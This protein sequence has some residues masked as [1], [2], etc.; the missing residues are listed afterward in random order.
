MGLPVLIEG[1]SGSGK[2][3]SLK[4][5]K[6]GEIS[7]FNVAGKPL[8]FKNNGIAVRSVERLMRT[9]GIANRY[10][11]ITKAIKDS[12]TKAFAIDDSQYLLAFD[13]F[14][15]AKEFGYGK[16]TD[17]AVSFYNLIKFV[18]NDLPSDVI[19]YFLHHVELTDGGKYK[20]KTIGK[21]LDNQLTVEGLF[22]IVLFCTADENHHYF[23]TQ[24]RGISTA[25][26]PE[27]MFDDEIENDLKFV[28]TKIREY[29]NLTPN[30]IK[31]EEK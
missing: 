4:N 14:D 12:K 6:P 17:M 1:E 11:V 25:K 29:W 22:S 5:F 18:I 28:D 20:A 19:V 9:S 26:S 16:F 13:S 23:I 7:I 3:R 31:S 2:S 24:S 30:N 8:P 15:K 27:D 21:M 10:D